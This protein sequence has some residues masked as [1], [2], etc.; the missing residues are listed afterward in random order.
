MCFSRSEA[1]RSRRPTARAGRCSRGGRRA[2]SSG[3]AGRRPPSRPSA[4]PASPSGASGSSGR[5]IRAREQRRRVEARIEEAHGVCAKPLGRAA[6]RAAASPGSPAARRLRSSEARAWKRRSTRPPARPCRPRRR[7]DDDRVRHRLG[8][9][10]RVFDCEH[11]D[12]RVAEHDD[13]DRDRRAPGEIRPRSRRAT[14]KPAARSTR[15]R[16]DRCRARRRAPAVRSCPAARRHLHVVDLVPVGSST[17]ADR[18][19]RGRLVARARP[20][21]YLYG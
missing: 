10:A 9:A 2:I 14:S 8:T 5:G 18:A 12:D 15:G 7:P 3:C 19:D 1:R 4:A 13:C 17:P 21:A 11:A 20:A 16:T 6:C